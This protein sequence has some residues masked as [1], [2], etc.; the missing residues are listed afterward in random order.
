MSS[1]TS[2]R[3]SPLAWARRSS[4]VLASDSAARHAC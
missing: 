3:A 2:A 1:S 4:G